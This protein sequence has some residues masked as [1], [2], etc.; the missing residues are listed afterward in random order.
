MEKITP[1][2]QI[3]CVLTLLKNDRGH[4][5][6]D[7]LLKRAQSNNA[8]IE[9]DILN[10]ILNKLIYDRLVLE[11]TIREFTSYCISFEGFLFEG[12]EAK[13]L[14]DATYAEEQRLEITRLKTVDISSDQNQKTL[15]KLTNRLS[16]ATWFAFGAALLLLIWS[17]YSYYHPA[18]I[19]VNVKVN[20][21]K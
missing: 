21:G 9:G 19:P 16:W 3:D 20:I 12:Y 1:I 10:R 17:I 7:D 18:P 5:S 15:N 13:A 8:E 6:F 4:I 11:K 2:K 14:A